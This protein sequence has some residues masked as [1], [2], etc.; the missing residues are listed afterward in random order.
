MCRFVQSAINI[1]MRIVSIV[2]VVVTVIDGDGINLTFIEIKFKIKIMYCHRNKCSIRNKWYFIL[3]HQVATLRKA[4]AGL[5][6]L[7]NGSE[8]KERIQQ[9]RND[10]FDFNLMVHAECMQMKRQTF[11]I[12]CVL[13][14]NF[15][16]FFIVTFFFIFFFCR[17]PI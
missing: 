15:R 2:V 16:S 1:A 13:K 4:K 3:K 7:I 10:N 17:N 11:S 12:S 14:E 5:T 8:K 6:Q 9:T